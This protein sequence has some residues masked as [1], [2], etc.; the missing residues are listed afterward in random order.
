MLDAERFSLR[1]GPYRAPRF[2]YGTRVNDARRG[3]VK[4]VGFSDAAI[5][6]PIGLKGSAKSLVLF[7]ALARAVR[8]ESNQAV[9]RAWGVSAQTVT[10]WRNAL[11]VGPTT[12]GTSKLRSTYFLEPWARKAQTKA[13]AKSRDPERRAKIAAARRGKPRPPHVVEALRKAHLGKP[14]SAETRRKMSE[15]HKGRGSWPPAAGRPWSAEEDALVRMLRIAEVI[16]RTGRTESAVKNRRIALRVPDGRTRAS[17]LEVG[18]S[19]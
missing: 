8:R 12:P 4:I 2:R 10:A 14:L 5:P 19:K 9:A 6:W 17:R 13:I 1:F 15:A 18:R 3:E 16:K 11:G 7:G